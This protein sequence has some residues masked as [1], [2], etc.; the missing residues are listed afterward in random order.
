MTSNVPVTKTRLNVLCIWDPQTQGYRASSQRPRANQTFFLLLATQEKDL[1]W[2]CDMSL[3][4]VHSVWMFLGKLVCVCV[5]VSPG[6]KPHLFGSWT[7]SGKVC[8]GEEF[9]HSTKVQL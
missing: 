8:A 4:P 7:Q 3:G 2:A 6:Y 9:T 1:A 5:C